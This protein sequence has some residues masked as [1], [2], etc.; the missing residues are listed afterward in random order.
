MCVQINPNSSILLGDTNHL[1]FF[2]AAGRIL[3]KAVM[4]NQLTPVH[5]VQPLYKHIMGWPLSLR[6]LEHIDDDVYR[7]LSRLLEIDDIACLELD[8]TVTEDR[9]GITETVD[10]IPN[11]SKQTVTDDRL[12]EYL[13]QQMQ[14][15]LMYRIKPQLLQFLMGFYDIVPEP[16]LAVFDFQEL[17]LLLHGLPNIQMEDWIA[18]TNYAG[19]FENK[20]NHVVVGWF[21]EVV[22]SFEQE[23]KAKLLQFVTGTAGVPAQGFGSL[24]GNDG[25]IRKFT[26]NGDKNVN[27]LPR[28]HTCFNRI[29]L[30]IYATKADLQ[31]YLTMAIC[32]ETTGFDIE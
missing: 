12:G 5:L 26:L 17:E 23:Q 15:R 11:G 10:L 3:G 13:V 14:Y 30:P 2:R 6:D 7:N 22:R 21:W 9:L 27:V 8:F 19:E 4:D 1:R 32:M 31:K 28:A 29:D 16:L 20:T 25:N 18:N 24:Q